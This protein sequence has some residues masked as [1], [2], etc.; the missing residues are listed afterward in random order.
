MASIYRNGNLF[1]IKLRHPLDGT[2]RRV[3]LQTADRA[4]ADLFRRK[5]E[6]HSQLFQPEFQGIEFPNALKELLPPLP[7][8][9]RPSRRSSEIF[10]MSNRW[11]FAIIWTLKSCGQRSRL[12]QAQAIKS[13]LR[14][15]EKM[16][17]F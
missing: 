5:W 17:L 12:V 4:W 9:E 6:A 14:C 16:P 1:W 3:S 15:P 2:E 11:F 13:I 10:P 8:A 7:V